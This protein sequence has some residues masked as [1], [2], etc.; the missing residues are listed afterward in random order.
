MQSSNR[1]RKKVELW[2]TTL[3]F[4]PNI[5]DRFE[6]ASMTPT[7]KN[8][9]KVTCWVNADSSSPVVL[10]A[11]SKQQQHR[12]KSCRTLERRMIPCQL[13]SLLVLQASASSGCSRVVNGCDSEPCDRSTFKSAMPGVPST[14]Q[15]DQSRGPGHRR[16]HSCANQIRR[17][18]T[19]SAHALA[20]AFCRTRTFSGNNSTGDYG[21]SPPPPLATSSLF[22]QCSWC[23]QVLMS[24][25]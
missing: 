22:L 13:V 9:S 21:T 15:G 2:Q 10:Q 3:K 16:A 17:V 19:Y 25:S 24:T 20:Y 5:S 1:N 7:I 12:R 11:P 4:K 6:S 18:S 14:G 8:T 23:I